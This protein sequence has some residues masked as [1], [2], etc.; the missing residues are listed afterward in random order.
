[1]L[2]SMTNVLPFFKANAEHNISHKDKELNA[3]WNSSAIREALAFPLE[4]TF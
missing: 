2:R 3:L 1:M 4:L